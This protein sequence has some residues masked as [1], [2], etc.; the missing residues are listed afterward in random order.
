MYY[1]VQLEIDFEVIMGI[2]LLFELDIEQLIISD[3]SFKSEVET[4]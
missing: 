4:M 2:S 3:T 1:K